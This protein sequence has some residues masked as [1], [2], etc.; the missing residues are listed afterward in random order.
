MAGRDGN[1]YSL[2]C[3]NDCTYYREGDYSKVF[4]FKPGQLEAMCSANATGYGYG[5]GYGMTS[6][7]SGGSGGGSGG[8]GGR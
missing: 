8:S 4:C 1:A 2:G 7:P 3:T 6:A 5:G